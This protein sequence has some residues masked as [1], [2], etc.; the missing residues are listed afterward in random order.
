MTFSDL[1]NIGSFI[2]GVAVLASLIFVGFQ[3]RQNT[4]AFRAAA[5]QAH[6]D[7]WK[8]I[9]SPVVEHEDVA[10]L[11]RIGLSDLSAL[12]E[13]QRVRFF[14]CAAGIFRFAKSAW[15]QWCS[16]L[17][18]TE[19]WEYAQGVMIQFASQPGMRSYWL[20]RRQYFSKEFQAWYEMLP[21]EH[22]HELYALPDPGRK[23]S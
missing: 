21:L 22:P 15:L 10:R 1:S 3:L 5:S 17:L 14:G 9:L 13:D 8:Q 12:S 11:W 19:H 6:T 18:D 2:S 23:H 4:K 16:G 7:T 20:L